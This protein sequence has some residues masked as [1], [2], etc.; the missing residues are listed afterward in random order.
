MEQVPTE[1][2]NGEFVI[3]TDRMRLD[4]DVI[5]DFLT[6]LSY[7]AIGRPRRV[8]QRSIEN[9]LCFGLYHGD[10]QIGFARVVTDYATFA[11]VADVFI[12]E[13]W[14]GRGL[15]K[16]LMQVIV[17]HPEL[18]LLRRWVL[19]T[20]DA[21]SLYEHSGFTR[22]DQPERFMHKFVHRPAYPYE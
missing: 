8:I 22:I 9:S 13:R 19:T 17:D 3:S 4:L 11:W 15:A 6:K 16:W 21:H 2:H 10:D 12:L 18:Q 20:K 14:R 1:W 5:C 7:W